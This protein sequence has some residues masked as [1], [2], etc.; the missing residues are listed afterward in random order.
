VY[1]C[2]D[3]QA[4]AQG[5]PGASMYDQ[6]IRE[7]FELSNDMKSACGTYAQWLEDSTQITSKQLNI[8]LNVIQQEWFKVSS[9]KL[10][11]PNM[12]EDY[13]SSFNEMS[14]SLLQ[15]VIN[16]AD[17][18]GNT[19]L[20]YAVSHCNVDIVNLLL[21]SGLCDVDKQNKA[22]YTAIMLASL[23]QVQSDGQKHVIRR[24][25]G[26]GSVNAKAAQAG[27]TALMLAVSHGRLDMVKLLIEAGANINAQDD[28]GSTALMCASEHGHTDI[29]RELL[30][31]S[32]C[33]PTITD[34]DGSTALSI[35][36]EVG[37]KEI[38]V[39][40]YAKVQFKAGASP[41]LARSRSKRKSTSPT[42]SPRMIRR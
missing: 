7:T 37:H 4:I 35:A 2:K 15:N 22:G 24:L 19:A 31:H 3:D 12:V 38:G 41:V 14:R 28:D 10:S 34:N 1:Q 36:M 6:N 17:A 33:D 25:F 27:Q 26:M 42:T 32:E 29:V 39:L 20:H 21:D 30:S 9:H 18:N 8:S 5:Q 11:N 40:L 16:I 23:A 13:L